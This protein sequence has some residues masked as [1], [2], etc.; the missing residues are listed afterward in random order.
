M[1]ASDG[2][3][4]LQRAEEDLLGVVGTADLDPAQAEPVSERHAGLYE[5]GGLGELF[6]TE[7]GAVGERVIEVVEV[8]HGG[9]D[10]ARV[11]RP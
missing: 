8:G 6:G 9:H 7:Q 1:S 4:R 11:P 2:P 3:G 5:H 10:A